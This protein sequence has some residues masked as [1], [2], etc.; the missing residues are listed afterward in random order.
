MVPQGSCLRGGQ[1]VNPTGSEARVHILLPPSFLIPYPEQ[2]SQHPTTFLCVSHFQISTSTFQ[3]PTERCLTR[4]P[5]SLIYYGFA[6]RTLPL[7]GPSACLTVCLYRSA[8]R[9]Q[10]HVP[11]L[12]PTKLPRALPDLQPV[13]CWESRGELRRHA[14]N[15]PSWNRDAIGGFSCKQRFGDARRL[16]HLVR[17][18]PDALM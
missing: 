2:L 1:Y 6:T 3:R 5:A 12:D 18:Q 8:H 7:V 10:L 9:P 16:Q 4:T 11:N 14:S 13:P 15:P 17:L